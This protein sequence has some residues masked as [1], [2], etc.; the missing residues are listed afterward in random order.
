P[1]QGSERE[2]E[3]THRR[4]SDARRKRRQRRAFLAL[5]GFRS[6]RS[7]VPK[8]VAQAFAD[9]IRRG[10]S[11][12]LKTGHVGDMPLDA[13]GSIVPPD[14]LDLAVQPGNAE[15]LGKGGV[16]RGLA[17]AREVVHAAAFAPLR[18]EEKGGGNVAHVD[19]IAGRIDC[20]D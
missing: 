20:P 10:E 5:E 11:E 18:E 6:L 12:P 4:P 15:Q 9:G 19:E 17:S 1:E 16:N 7:M 14:N 2:Q 8:E 13:G 3:E